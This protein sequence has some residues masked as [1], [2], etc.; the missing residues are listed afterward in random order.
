VIVTND[1]IKCAW[2]DCPTSCD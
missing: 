2:H 1:Q